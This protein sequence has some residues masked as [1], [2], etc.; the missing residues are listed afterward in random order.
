MDFAS[1]HAAPA[2]SVRAS[3]PGVEELRQLLALEGG[4]GRSHGV[5]F[6][7][8]TTLVHVADKTI[9][10]FTIELPTFIRGQFTATYEDFLA[11]EIA[12]PVQPSDIVSKK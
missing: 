10:R 2:P 11:L 12:A 8:A 3:A 5:A 1:G 6:R 7:G 4:R 9:G